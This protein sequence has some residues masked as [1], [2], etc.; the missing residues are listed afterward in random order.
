MNLPRV[1]TSS[2]NVSILIYSEVAL[3]AALN[4]SLNK[5]ICMKLITTFAFL[6]YKSLVHCPPQSSK[7]FINYI[8]GIN[9]GSCNAQFTKITSYISVLSF[10]QQPAKVWRL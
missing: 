8:V 9:H 7:T 2:T 4:L 1:S 3:S 5:V 10:I 6:F